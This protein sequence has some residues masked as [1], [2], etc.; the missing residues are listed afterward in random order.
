MK[1]CL[2]LFLTLNL[3]ANSKRFGARLSHRLNRKFVWTAKM[4]LHKILKR[5]QQPAFTVAITRFSLQ[6]HESKS[7]R[8]W[9]EA[10]RSCLIV[11][12]ALQPYVEQ[13]QLEQTHRQTDRQTR[14]HSHIPRAATPRGIIII[15]P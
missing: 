9:L 14:T 12:V 6:I 15:P 13:L 8:T 11:F 5:Q 2:L 3:V 7:K 4:I 1:N 10:Y